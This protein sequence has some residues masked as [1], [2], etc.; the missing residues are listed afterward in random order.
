MGELRLLRG[1]KA[2]P[3]PCPACRRKFPPGRRH[4]TRPGGP[5]C[6][7]Q[8]NPQRDLARKLL[9][10]SHDALATWFLAG[11]YERVIRV[12][13]KIERDLPPAEKPATL[14]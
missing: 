11:E 5:W 6:H 12:V 7:M 1:E 14:T 9:A 8:P 2:D 13:G 10:R 3:R 4:K